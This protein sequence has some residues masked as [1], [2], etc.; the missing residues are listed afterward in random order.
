M[1]VDYSQTT[2]KFTKSD[3]YPLPNIGEQANSLAKYK[4]S[5]TLDLKR[6]CDQILLR[7][8]DKGY[9]AFKADGQLWQFTVLPFGGTSGVAC[10][11]RIID[12]PIGY[13]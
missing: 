13:R 1:V 11:Q 8:A 3:A 5:S 2:N 7:D 10:F 9:T 6:A 4:I 12:S